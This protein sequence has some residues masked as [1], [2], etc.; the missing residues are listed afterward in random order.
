MNIVIFIIFFSF[1]ILSL[2]GFILGLSFILSL[3]Y[4]NHA[5]RIGEQKAKVNYISLAILFIT[6]A[7]FDITSWPSIFLAA[8]GG[9]SKGIYAFYVIFALC[10]IGQLVTLIWLISRLK[11]A[12]SARASYI[13]FI[14]MWLC[15]FLF[16][17]INW[18]ASYVL[19]IL[20]WAGGN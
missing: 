9:I 7:I 5:K 16:F 6:F 8:P 15:L 17:L 10:L 1:I 14:I 19:V 3:C 4:I 18:A 20:S 11:R 13:K 12:A 2:L